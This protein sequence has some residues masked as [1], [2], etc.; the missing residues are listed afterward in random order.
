MFR[1][2]FLCVFG[3]GLPVSALAESLQIQIRGSVPERLS[4][5]L[6]LLDSASAGCQDDGCR[7]RSNTLR[8]QRNPKGV[9]VLNVVIP[10]RATRIC[11]RKLR[12]HKIAKARVFFRGDQ[13]PV[14]LKRGGAIARD[15]SSGCTPKSVNIAEGR[16]WEVS[17]QEV[18]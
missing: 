13:K 11:L 15:G 7:I 14:A 1:L 17:I 3:L 18:R 8:I 16:I 6:V 12:S 9:G 5:E 2:I 10:K 4:V